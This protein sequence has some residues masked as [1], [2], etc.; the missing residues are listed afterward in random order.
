MHAHKFTYVSHGPYCTAW[1]GYPWSAPSIPPWLILG[2][3]SLCVRPSLSLL[4]P[5]D[6]NLMVGRMLNA[7]LPSRTTKPA[8]PTGQSYIRPFLTSLMIKLHPED[9]RTIDPYIM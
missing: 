6:F 9:V 2:L 5:Q 3:A 8:T 7:I 4:S 1:R